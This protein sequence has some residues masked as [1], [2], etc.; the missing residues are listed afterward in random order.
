M[1]V[2]WLDLVRFADTI[3]YHSDNNM[4]V[5]P[6]RDYVIN[7]FNTNKRFDQF[8]IEQ[9]AGDLLPNPTTEQKVATAYNR[10][11]QTTEEGGAQAQEYEVKNLTDRVRN[12]STV[13]MASTMG[14]CQCHDH[15][16]DPFTQKD[17]Y[18]MGAFFADV[19]EA[20]IGRR[21]PGIPIPTAEQEQELKTADE[22]IAAAKEKLKT[23]TATVA[24]EQE[25]WEK[26]QDATKADWKVLDATVKTYE[27]TVLEKQADGSYRAAG[28][29]P[30]KDSYTF[31]AAPDLIGITGIRI[32]AMPDDKFAGH[33]PG[34]S[35]NGNFV[36]TAVKVATAKINERNKPVVLARATAD[37]SQEGFLASSL[38]TGRGTGWGV[39]PK[40]GEGHVLVVE[41]RAPI[42][43]DGLISLEISLE[44][45]SKFPQH[46]LGRVRV[47][48]TTSPAPGGS[49]SLPGNVGK[50]LAIESG[51]RTAQQKSEMA[52]YFRT[53]APSLQ[54]V[55]NE[56]AKLEK[57]KENLTNGIS[58]CLVT[59]AATPRVVR[60][61]HR[62]N[63]LDTTGDVMMPAIPRFLA[64]QE[65]Q[66]EA[67]KRRLTRM[68]LAKWIASRDN[69]LTARTYVNRLW[70][71]YF[72]TGI[73]KVMDDLGSQGEWPTHPELMDWMAVESNT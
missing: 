21:E 50:I 3:G 42:N 5:S 6:Y 4:N 48:V 72:G 1:A 35:E 23:S 49:M 60:V 40:F 53:I 34:A 61:L 52:E 27:G 44:F 64:S 43:A 22:Q 7:A 51:Q 54:P 17:F 2:F 46:E 33:G 67:A 18:S 13:W 31:T 26:H 16:F 15:K 10:L 63:W 41:P 66:D 14:C 45:H 47:S 12:V 38:V 11:L 20:A 58:K 29:L 57:Q 25:K 24:E 8:T 36:L 59:T 37:F 69:P 28:K 19:Q 55:R 65:L 32:E 62:G 56:I 71:L 30:D 68:D 39:L 9:L 70:R 73:S